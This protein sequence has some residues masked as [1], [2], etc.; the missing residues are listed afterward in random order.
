MHHIENLREV[1]GGRMMEIHEPMSPQTLDR[2]D[3]SRFA[4]PHR[5]VHSGHQRC[6]EAPRKK[7]REM[8]DDDNQVFPAV[9]FSSGIPVFPFEG[10][11]RLDSMSSTM[12][13]PRPMDLLPKFSDPN[14][15]EAF[16]QEHAPIVIEPDEEREP[17]Q[18]DEEDEGE[19]RQDG[20]DVR[21]G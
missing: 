1:M 13:V 4:T 16:N 3:E 18:M 19:T 6:P 2:M 15:I 14:L 8:V 20:P 9:S 12:S 7:S 5:L 21:Q 10:L 11:Q 17:V